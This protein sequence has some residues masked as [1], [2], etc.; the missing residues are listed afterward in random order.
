[1][2]KNQQHSQQRSVLESLVGEVREGDGVDPRYEKKSQ[3]MKTLRGKPNYAALRLGEQI[4]DTLVETLGQ[5]EDS[6]LASF[7]VG[8]VEPSIS[9]GVYVVQVYSNDPALEYDTDEVKSLLQAL[10]PALR[11]EVARAVSRRKAPDFRFEV[12]P[13]HVQPRAEPLRN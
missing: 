3:Q 11:S 10:K 6:L 4:H 8:S 7:S 12:L 1:M 5:S 2:A 13:P 9:G